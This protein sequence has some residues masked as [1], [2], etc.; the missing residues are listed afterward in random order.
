M[1]NR[2][3]KDVP[4]G[5]S[6]PV[7]EDILMF[8]VTRP[9]VSA[10]TTLC[11]SPDVRMFEL[12]RLHD[13]RT[14]FAFSIPFIDGFLPRRPAEMNNKCKLRFSNRRARAQK[15]LGARYFFSLTFPFYTDFLY[16]CSAYDAQC[17]TLNN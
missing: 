15:L 17:T 3:G 10:Q 2:T 7:S 11:L 8:G 6:F 16:L 1:K 14:V 4:A 12:T 5:T 9:Y 13:Y